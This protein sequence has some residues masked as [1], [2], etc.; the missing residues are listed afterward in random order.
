MTIRSNPPGALVYVDDYHVGTTPV[1]TNFTYYGTRKIRL[2]KDGYETLTVMQPIATPWYEIPPLDFF[3]ENLLPGELRDRRTLSYQLRPQTVVRTE[4]LLGRAEQLRARGQMPVALA[5]PAFSSPIPD[6]GSPSFVSPPGP[7]ESI[8]P[9]QA[10][11][12]H[13]GAQPL[14]AFPPSAQ[15]V[16]PAQPQGVPGYST[17][18]PPGQ[19]SGSSGGWTPPPGP[20]SS[21]GQ[22]GSQ[23]PTPP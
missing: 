5:P 23:T 20:D 16:Q 12:L 6:R 1:S 3:T 9:P 18:A 10:Q 15:P 2:V 21:Q 8:P 11:P 4:Q 7:L 22:P 17:P 14:Q 13:P 19:P